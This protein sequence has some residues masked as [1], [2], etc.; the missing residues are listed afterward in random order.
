MKLKIALMGA[1]IL[2]LGAAG[3]VVAQTAT[4]TT[5]VGTLTAG[6]AHP[7]QAPASTCEALA[8]Q[9]LQNAK[10]TGAATVAAG[11]YTP[12]GQQGPDAK[13]ENLPAHCA[14]TATLTPSAD[15]D[16]KMALWLPTSGWNGKFMM[17]GNGGWN[18]SISYPAMAE[19]LRRGYAVASTDTGHAGSRGTFAFGH[20]EKLID[21]AWRAVHETAVKGKALTTTYYGGTPRYSYWDGCSSGGKQG[22]KEVQMFPGD[23]DGVIAGAPANNWV[24]LQT[25][26]LVANIANLPKGGAAVLGPQQFAI[27]H[28][29]VLD[30]CDASDG[31]KDSQVQ[32][33]RTCSFKASSLICKAG[34][35]AGTCL[36]PAQAAA[37]DKIYSPVHNPRTGELIY[38]GMP[39][40][41]ELTWGPVISRRWDTGADTFAL[42]ANNPNWDFYTLDLA[43][44]VTAAEQSPV[45][46]LLATSP[47]LS[48]FK[49][50]G[51]KI[52][53]YHGWA[54]PFIPTENSINYYESV[55]AKQG[56]LP[57][58]QE[59][60][61]LFLVPAMGHCRGAYTFD[62]ITPLEEWV[63]RD[64][65]PDV[66]LG[67][68]I[69]PPGVTPKPPP[70]G[71][72]VFAPEY[73]I[74]P[75]CAYPEIARVQGGNG[76]QPQD[77]ICLPGPRGARPGH[78][79]DKLGA[80]IA[81]R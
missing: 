33:P 17:V 20:P 14:V 21:F 46:I 64:V 35:A 34:A 63:E 24:R 9:A 58:T 6:V 32:D 7:G 37:A 43:K 10:I 81:S 38:P 79:P 68:H 42:A 2:A 19:P 62:W 59:F 1:S 48:A 39:P 8:G 11:P 18:G 22:L 66:V 65:A 76:E 26:S 23:F 69:P 74:R 40:G 73:G 44:D 77:W 27:L 15:S 31:L 72:V 61:R 70:P 13:P 55:A 57:Q 51:G 12:P 60:Y 30:Q 16:I 25:Q 53:Q 3:A 49:A 28:K 75:M 4:Q 67:D 52:I 54:D 45:G 78:G 56:G 80:Q 5:R 41:S 36:T 47:D 29:G 71:A 50:R